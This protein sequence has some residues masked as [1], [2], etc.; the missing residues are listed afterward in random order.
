LFSLDRIRSAIQQSLAGVASRS[1]P[2]KLDLKADAVLKQEAANADLLHSQAASI[3]TDTGLRRFIVYLI[4][5]LVAIVVVYF[6]VIT[7]LQILGIIKEL[8]L[9]SA[10]F[11]PGGVLAALV[12]A[13]VWMLR[14]P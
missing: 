4:G 6:L 10:F 8:P 13:L 5:C 3:R 14:R 7:S 1:V 11:A 12:A 2:D 9:M